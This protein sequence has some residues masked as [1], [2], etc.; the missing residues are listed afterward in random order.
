MGFSSFLMGSVHACCVTGGCFQRVS[1]LTCNALSTHVINGSSSSVSTLLLGES[2][3]SV[4]ALLVT[5]TQ[6]STGVRSHANGMVVPPT[7]VLLVT[8]T[9]QSHSVSSHANRDGCSSDV[10][11]S[12]H[13]DAAVPKCYFARQWGW[14]FL[15]RRFF[16]SRKTQQSQSVSSHANRDGCSSDVGS[17]A[18][19]PKCLCAHRWDGCSSDVASS[20]SRRRSSP[21]VIVRTPMGWL[22]LRGRFFLVTETQQS[23]SDCSHANGMVVSPTSVLLV[24]ETQQSQSVCSHANG[25]GCSSEVASSLSRRRSSP[26]VIV[27]TPMGW[28]FLR[29]RFFLVT[30]TQQSQSDCSHAN[31]MVVPPTS[32][33]P[34]HGDAAVSK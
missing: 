32:L 19:V 31:G 11:S 13:G 15:R 29:G 4:S 34:C 22:F 1:S 5:E 21:K 23:Q 16:L 6:K 33:L 20:L 17:D 10:G 7:S 2:D 30:E 28:L 14:L 26:K 8:E 3:P 18:A 25:D 12:C 24:T 27:R 9:Q